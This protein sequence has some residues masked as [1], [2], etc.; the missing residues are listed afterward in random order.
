MLKSWATQQVHHSLCTTTQQFMCKCYITCATHDTANN[1]YSNSQ[2]K[3]HETHLTDVEACAALP[4]PRSAAH[5]STTSCTWPGMLNRALP[6]MA[7]ITCRT[8]AL[9]NAASMSDCAARSETAVAPPPAATPSVMAA[10]AA[11]VAVNA[12]WAADVR[13]WWVSSRPAVHGRSGQAGSH[14]AKPRLSV[15]RSEGSEECR[16][17]CEVRWVLEK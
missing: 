8:P 10:S 6:S 14:C 15:A 7:C 3:T 5:P 17:A 13:C 11:C 12:A 16:E 1:Q 9:D 2:W 4:S